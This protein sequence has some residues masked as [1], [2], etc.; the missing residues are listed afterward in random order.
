M[1]SSAQLVERL[2]LFVVLSGLVGSLFTSAQQPQPQPQQDKCPEGRPTVIV[3]SVTELQKAVNDPDCTE[4]IVQGGVYEVNLAI[5]RDNLTIKSLAG[6]KERPTFKGIEP[7]RQTIAIAKSNKVTIQGLIITR[8]Q[9]NIGILVSEQSK[10]IKLIDN[11]IHGYPEAGISIANSQV[12]LEGN[13]ISD[14][15]EIRDDE[16]T[17]VGV[18]IVNSNVSMT[19]NS[20]KRNKDGIEITNSTVTLG[21]NTISQNAGCGIKAD[22][23]SA[24]RAPSDDRRNWIFGNTGGNT[25]P[26]ELSRTIRRPEI[27]VPSHFAKIQEAIKD[28]EPVRGEDDRPYMIL[29]QQGEYAENLCLDRSVTIIAPAGARIRLT[30]QKP[31]IT[32]GTKDCPLHKEEKGNTDKEAGDQ[33]PSIR[34]SISNISI[35]GPST[36]PTADGFQI[37]TLHSDSTQRTFL[38]VKLQDSTIEKFVKGLTISPS[39]KGHKLDVQILGTQSLQDAVC[40]SKQYP[41]FLKGETPP[42]PSLASIRD[43]QEGIRLENSEQADL[44]VHVKDVEIKGNTIGIFYEGGGDSKLSIERSRVIENQQGIRV[45]SKGTNPQ[46]LDEFTIQLG[47]I[48][49]NKV[50]GMKLEST[51]RSK[52]DSKLI[53]VDIRQNAGFGVYIQ[54]NTETTLKAS[55]DI[56]IS[57][58]EPPH[59]C[60]ITDNLGPGVRAHGSAV[61]TVEN[62][63]VDGNGYE[64][65]KKTKPIPRASERGAVKVGPDGLFASDSVQLIVRN[66]YVGPNNAGVGIALQA[67]NKDDKLKAVLTD[68]YIDSNRKWGI[69]Y[70]TRSCLAEAAMPDNFY[71]RVEGQNN[72]LVGNGYRL[73]RVEQAAGPDQ[74]LGR[75][76]VCPKELD[77]L[78]VRV[79]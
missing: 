37:G 28:A 30:A 46:A 12:E 52:L 26:W 68:N 63:Y 71:G 55:S 14:N 5:L 78:V 33:R 44:S 25:C 42:T 1:R 11:V 35:I 16:V 61:L 45:T 69:S 10:E 19:V 40:T 43:N 77:F 67:S 54:G 6:D 7:R 48:W 2:A 70:I 60:G 4:I 58:P 18:L 72:V 36:S 20:I 59:N 34:I 65:D 3:N 39:A 15:F 29:L 31:T 64:D 32:V 41:S 13:Q 75:G 50:G 79:Q 74:G 22:A 66:T 24:V 21:E 73:S 76:Q 53:D 62:M 49:Q 56:P 9:G 8:K 51:V 47:R 27:H 38:K 57:S 17:G 23:K